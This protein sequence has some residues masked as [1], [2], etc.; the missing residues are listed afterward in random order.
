MGVT[1]EW[2]LRVP[3][4]VSDEWLLAESAHG[5]VRTRAQRSQMAPA[6]ELDE[7]DEEFFVP[8]TV[9]TAPSAGRRNFTTVNR[10]LSAIGRLRSCVLLRRTPTQTG[11][12]NSATLPVHELVFCGF[13]MIL[14][15][16]SHGDFPHNV[17]GSMRGRPQIGTLLHCLSKT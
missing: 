13:L 10:A 12:Q 6:L 15:A 9:S 16:T 3:V 17:V 1:D 8:K 14:S 2:S 11:S 7:L 4:S 5:V